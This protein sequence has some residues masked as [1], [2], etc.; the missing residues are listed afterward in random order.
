MAIG[1]QLRRWLVSRRFSLAAAVAAATLIAYY[2]PARAAAESEE[3]FE[4]AVS[5]PPMDMDDPGTPGSR[6]IEVNF[7]GT[8][9]KLGSA[10]SSESLFDANYGIGDRLQLKYERP[11]VTEQPDGSD[12]QQGLGAT[13]IGVKWR[14]MDSHGLAIAF[15]PQ[16]QFD[17]GFTLKDEDGNPEESEGRSAYFPLLISESIGE[18]FT[19]AA[20]YGYRRNL[21]GRGDDNNIALGVG[22]GI[23]WDG[24]ILAE[25]FSE[26]DQNFDNRQTDVRVGVFFLPFPKTFE[27]S[28]FEA[29]L[30]ASLGHSIGRTEA[31]EFSTSFTFGFSVIRKPRD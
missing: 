29:P 1:F 14:F 31:G 27:H 26:R 17:D 20:N 18:H 21:D 23:G 24:R 3:A 15:Y 25:V 28:S 12:M 9:I 16:Y 10:R 30:F 2:A 11:Y 19:L 5:S 6:G 7:V 8:L 4:S 22:R 13:E